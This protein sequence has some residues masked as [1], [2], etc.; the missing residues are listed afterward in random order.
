MAETTRNGV[1]LWYDV[2][3]SGEPL[4]LIGGFALLHNQFEFCDPILHEAGVQT[5]HWNY[6][7]S[8]KSDWTM[9]E[10]FTLEGWVEDLKAVLDAAG[11]E[12][13]NIWCTS[14]STPIGMRFAAKYPERVKSLITYPYYKVDDYWRDVFHAAYW[15]AHVFGITQL[16]RVF[17]GVVLTAKTLYTPDHFKYEK[18]A[19][20]HYEANVNMTT[21]KELMETLSSTDLTG[22]IPRIQCPVMLLMG[23]ES[24]LNEEESMESASFDRL[25]SDFLALKPDAKVQAV[26]GAGSTYCMI[27][28]PEETCGLVIDYLKSHG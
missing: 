15:V 4:L 26:K 7:G 21:M 11:I 6:R 3:G 5:I 1:R 13:T 27:T 19:A 23:N 28:N 17:A 22:D 14:T 25:I 20:P 16:S 24:A 9:T 12:K 2:Q 18:W 8:G 10:P